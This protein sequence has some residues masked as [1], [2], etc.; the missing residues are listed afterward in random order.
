[1]QTLDASLPD[2]AARRRAAGAAVPELYGALVDR[3]RAALLLTPPDGDA[4]PPWVAVDGGRRWE[5]PMS[6]LQWPA[7]ETEP[8]YPYL[9]TVGVSDRARVL[10]DAARL[11]GVVAVEGDVGRGID[12]VWQLCGR[13]LDHP[14]SASPAISMAGF[15]S[16]PDSPPA[17]RR[18]AVVDDLRDDG[19]GG[20]SGASTQVIT[21]TRKRL[22]EAG[23]REFGF[24]AHPSE[25]DLD[26][27]R[28][29]ASDA[30]GA[31]SVWVLGAVPGAPRI[32]IDAQGRLDIPALGLSATSVAVRGAQ[33]IG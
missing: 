27:L 30:G 1:L 22:P 18:L 14:W 31:L 33:G 25:P 13:L 3:D 16:G 10:V 4:V 29:L 19:V 11:D 15:A 2:L 12:F 8:P 23:S 5:A 9:V 26:H 28:R 32:T 17:V 6:G 20:A 21:G 24:A 7:E